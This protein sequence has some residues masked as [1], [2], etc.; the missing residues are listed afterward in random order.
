MSKFVKLGLAPIPFLLLFVAHPAEATVIKCKSPSGE[1]TYTQGSCP[2]GTSP[3]ELPEGVSAN[4]DSH[5]RSALSPR[6]QELERMDIHEFGRIHRQC[7]DEQY[8]K[9]PDCVA[10]REFWASR[11]TRADKQAEV[12]QANDSS[13]CQAGDQTACV[14]SVCRQHKPSAVLKPY[15]PYVGA[16]ADV[17]ACSSALGLPSSTQW[18]QIA[19]VGDRAE[20]V[21]LRKLDMV[22][23]QGAAVQ[24]RAAFSVDR[25]NAAGGKAADGFTTPVFRNQVF[26]TISAAVNQSCK[27]LIDRALAGGRP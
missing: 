18:A 14:A 2:A 22:G 27:E 5:G 21:C 25:S 17:R 1:I 20:F 23:L 19:E 7:M 8:W 26:P 6:A 24:M 11:K 15:T 10:L 13:Q 16:D 3:A 9:T 12:T 4:A